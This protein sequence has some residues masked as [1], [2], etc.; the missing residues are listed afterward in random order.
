MPT[1]LR[2]RAVTVIAAVI[3]FIAIPAGI[4]VTA[5]PALAASPICNSF[6]N[7]YCIGA[8]GISSGD[9]VELTLSGRQINEVAQNF[10]CCHGHEVYQLQFS[11]DTSKC[12]GVSSIGLTTVR[13][14]SAGN[15]S[16]VNWAKEPQTD[17]SVEWFSNPM[18]GFLASDNGLGDQLFVTAAACN[19]CL[20]KWNR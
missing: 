7:Q 5:V 12:V 16:N 6:G 2:R 15:A 10:T 1:I 14:C 3:S 8:P 19:G 13:D 20:L 17:G 9:P 4:A 11:A 18:N